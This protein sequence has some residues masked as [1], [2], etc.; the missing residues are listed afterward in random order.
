[1]SV[2]T[3]LFLHWTSFLMWLLKKTGGFPKSV[4]FTLSSRIDNLAM[5]VLEAVIEAQ[6]SHK[7]GPH[8]KRASM[9]IDKLRV[10]LR[11]AHEMAYLDHRGYEFASRRLTD[12][13]KMTGGW[14]KQQV[15]K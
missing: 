8:L 11:I 4:R 7:S 15:G 14:L 6:Y 10:F 3:P 12:A 9:G 5:D 1:M 2:D 13:G